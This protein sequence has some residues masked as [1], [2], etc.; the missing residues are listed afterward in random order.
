MGIESKEK[1]L[2]AGVFRVNLFTPPGSWE[3]GPRR[4]QK[5][6]TKALIGHGPLPSWRFVF[7]SVERYVVKPEGKGKGDSLK[8][9]R[10]QRT[11][12]LTEVPYP[13]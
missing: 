1:K 6:P 2:C 8:G 5:N 12:R 9:G 13:V 3:E 11:M 7:L 10:T 4:K